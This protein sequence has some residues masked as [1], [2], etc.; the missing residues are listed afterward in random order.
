MKNFPSQNSTFLGKPMIHPCTSKKSPS[1]RQKSFFHDFS[2][3]YLMAFM[4]FL[5]VNEQLG[6]VYIPRRWVMTGFWLF[7]TL[8]VGHFRRENLCFSRVGCLR[9]TWKYLQDFAN[10]LVM[11]Y[12]SFVWVTE[13]VGTVFIPSRWV[14]EI[15]WTMS[16]HTFCWKTW[17]F[18]FSAK[19]VFWHSPKYFAYPPRRCKNGFHMLSNPYT[20]HKSRN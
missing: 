18:S 5:W 7:S 4:S 9:V 12:M 2:I 20:A 17:F 19:C 1:S 16:K 10:H 6:T 8:T 13:H 15:F 14:Y 11:A 3:T